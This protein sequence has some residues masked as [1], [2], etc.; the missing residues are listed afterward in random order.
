MSRDQLAEEA[1]Q[2]LA[3]VRTASHDAFGHVV[4]G[5]ADALRIERLIAAVSERFPLPDERR[6]PEDWPCA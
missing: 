5:P 2:L 4:I 1:F 3:R 6:Q